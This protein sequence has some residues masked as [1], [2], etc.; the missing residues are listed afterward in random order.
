MKSLKELLKFKATSLEVKVAVACPEDEEVLNAI[1]EAYEL[2][3]CSFSLV[4]N[5][6]QVNQIIK[7]MGKELPKEFKLIDV[8]EPDQACQLAVKEVSEG[9]AQVLMKGLVDTS[10]ILKAVLNKEY[11]LRTNNVL[12]H[13]IVCELP[14]LKR[15][16]FLSDAAMIIDPSIPQ[17]KEITINAVSLAKSLGIEKPKVALIS[18]VEKINPKMPSTTKAMEVK[19]LWK[20]GEIKDC[21]LEGP[22]AVDLALSVEA[23]KTKKI[24]SPVAGNADILIV[25]FIEVGNALYKGWVFGCEGPKSAGI[26]LGA[27]APIVLTSRA[28][29]HEA[30]LYSIALAVRHLQGDGYE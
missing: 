13:V 10:V 14:Y 22:L 23:A 24:N 28:D 25:P 29:S 2:G 12:S 16:I 20:K 18:A 19:E 21:E 27:K 17:L 15:L 8:K 1:L 4:G 3:L 6:N 26:V 5:L 30:K 9:N 11:G 7:D